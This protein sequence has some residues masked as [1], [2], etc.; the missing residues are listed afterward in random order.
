MGLKL[1]CISFLGFLA[2]AVFGTCTPSAQVFVEIVKSAPVEGGCALKVTPLP[3]GIIRGNPWKE[4]PFCPLEYSDIQH[5][6]VF[7]QR[8]HGNCQSLDMQ[9]L[10]G[11]IVQRG[12]LFILE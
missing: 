2:P 3:D 8:D 11:V 9:I 10:S 7:L 5:S 12:D 6:T 1:F 4:D